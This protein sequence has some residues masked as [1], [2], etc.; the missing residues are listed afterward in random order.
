MQVIFII[1]DY[2]YL[3]LWIPVVGGTILLKL[4][5]IEQPAKA[6]N[7]LKTDGKRKQ[8]LRFSLFAIPLYRFLY[9]ESLLRFSLLFSK[10]KLIVTDLR[11]RCLTKT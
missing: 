8:L 4:T 6:V 1:I 11:K 3:Q 2:K 7:G 5:E 10:A 9:I